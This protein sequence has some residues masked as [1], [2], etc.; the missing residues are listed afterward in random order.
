MNNYF[1]KKYLLLLLFIPFALTLNSCVTKTEEEIRLDKYRVEL[2]VTIRN[3]ITELESIE[4]MLVDS[5]EALKL[6]MEDKLK[7]YRKIDSIRKLR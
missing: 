6:V 1:M 3:T 5:P 4:P 2:I 7:Y